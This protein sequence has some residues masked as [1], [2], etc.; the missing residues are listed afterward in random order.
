MACEI[1]LADVEAYGHQ[2][3]AYRA[4]PIG[5]LL[6]DRREQNAPPFCV[7][8]IREGQVVEQESIKRDCRFRCGL[9]ADKIGKLVIRCLRKIERPYHRFLAR[10]RNERGR[11]D[12]TKARQFVL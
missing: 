1:M 6:R 9:K 8:L 3:P 11:G 10:Q 7:W 2:F 4:N 5:K 12:D